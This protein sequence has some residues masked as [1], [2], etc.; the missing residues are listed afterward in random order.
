MNGINRDSKKKK[1]KKSD[2]DDCW[3]DGIIEKK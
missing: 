1:K 2:L 3:D